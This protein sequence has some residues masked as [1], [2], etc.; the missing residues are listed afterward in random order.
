MTP[1]LA[2]VFIHTI[3]RFNNLGSTIGELGNYTIEIDWPLRKE[4]ADT[5]YFVQDYKFIFR[6]DWVPLLL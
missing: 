1:V 5:F 4:K 2:L 3:Y 6:K